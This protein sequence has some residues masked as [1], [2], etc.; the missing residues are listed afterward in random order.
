MIPPSYM[1]SHA[2]VDSAQYP[3]YVLI[4]HDEGAAFNRLRPA[5]ISRWPPKAHQA[6]L[7]EYTNKKKQSRKTNPRTCFDR[8]LP[9]S[10]SNSELRLCIMNEPSTLPLASHFLRRYP[11]R[12]IISESEH[13]NASFH[14]Q[15]IRHQ[16]PYHLRRPYC[17][18][19]R[20]QL[21]IRV[22]YIKVTE[23]QFISGMNVIP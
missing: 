17:P 10:P 19:R 9:I 13:V 18:Y 6:A 5:S 16:Q 7:P 4:R 14:H 3:T 8:H 11:S 22:T 23:Q 12:S 15:L 1:L 21:T 2:K 20:Q